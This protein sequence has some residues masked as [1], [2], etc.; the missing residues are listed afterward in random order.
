M[1]RGFSK[2]CVQEQ[3]NVSISLCEAAAE[4]PPLAAVFRTPDDTNTVDRRRSIS[5][6]IGRSVI[7]TDDFIDPG[8]RLHGAKC[9]RDPICLIV[10]WNDRGNAQC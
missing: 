4:R 9:R 6:A 1:S 7:D 2:V 5:R 3:K 10:C 8:N